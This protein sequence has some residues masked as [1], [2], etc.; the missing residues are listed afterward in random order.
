MYQAIFTYSAIYND[1]DTMM[2]FTALNEL[3]INQIKSLIKIVL[4]FELYFLIVI[5]LDNST[6]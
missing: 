2:I 4:M 3:Q 6:Q 5:Y 1:H